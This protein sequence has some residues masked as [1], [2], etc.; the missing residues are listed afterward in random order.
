MHRLVGERKAFGA[1]KHGTY[2]QDDD[3]IFRQRFWGQQ[4]DWV[5]MAGVWKSAWCA[6]LGEF[7]QPHDPTAEVWG[8]RHGI[9]GGIRSLVFLG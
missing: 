3:F 7:G 4:D 1:T 9:S 6:Q 5:I 2:H 8:F